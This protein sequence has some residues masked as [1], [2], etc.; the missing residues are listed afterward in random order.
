M[1]K[2]NMDKPTITPDSEWAERFEVAFNQIHHILKRLN[3]NEYND[4]FMKLL[5]DSSRKH[6]V[7]Q[8]VYYDL[9]QF[10]K[11]R[12]ALVHEKLERKTFIAIPH[13]NTVLKIENIA[14]LLSKPPTVLDIATAFVVSVNL[15]TPLQDLIK[16]MGT[17]SYN[18]FPVY[19]KGVFQFLISENGL[20]KWM[21]ASIHK[22]SIHVEGKT[23]ENLK[24]YE[25]HHNVVFVKRSMDIFELEDIYEESFQKKR[26]LE[27]V[28]ITQNGSPLEAPLG[29]VTSWDLIEIDLLVSRD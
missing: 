20:T 1:H 24:P 12:N 18:Q 3:P 9:R 10:A 16:I 27:A 29:I 2:S 13:E 21:A 14:K 23:V 4:A 19:E 11:L 26:K 28:I 8:Q 22:G 17:S 7:I 25:E 6:R 15:T 5:T